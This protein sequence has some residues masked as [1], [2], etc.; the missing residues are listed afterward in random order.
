MDEA[1]K[2]K[3]FELRFRRKNGEFFVGELYVMKRLDRFGSVS[4]NVS[5]FRDINERKQAELDLRESE[6]HRYQL[7]LELVY[8]AQ[9]QAKLL[10]RSYLQIPDFD[11]AAKCLPA[12]QVGGDF[13]D[14]Q[15]VSPNLFD[16]TLG[17]VMGKG[18]AAAILMA[19]VRAVLHAVTL[20][21]GP[22]Q[23]LQ[24]AQKALFDDLENAESFVTL[25]HGRLDVVRRTLTFVDCG[26]GFVFLR[27]ANGSVESLTPS[28]LPF[29]VQAGEVYQE[30]T[31]RFEKGDV[32]V[33]YSDGLIDANPQLLLTNQILSEQMAGLETALDI[34]NRLID[35]TGR[36]DPQPDDITVLVARCVG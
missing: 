14:W 4:G 15:R 12:K 26:H 20:Y 23:A 3:L 2:G 32:L 33:L 34:V 21:N 7:Q 19:T 9:I 28:G 30:G 13:Y 16:L 27:K 22:A 1:N 25:F 36:P 8:A 5:I 10:P 24:L 17:D 29:G 31:V 35:L 18:M 11:I 6:Q